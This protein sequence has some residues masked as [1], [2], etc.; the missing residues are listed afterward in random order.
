MF[1]INYSHDI[2]QGIDSPVQPNERPDVFVYIR[3]SVVWMCSSWDTQ[4]WVLYC[5]VFLTMAF[6]SECKTDDLSITAVAVV[7]AG[8]ALSSALIRLQD[9]RS[10]AGPG[11]GV[12]S[13]W[14]WWGKVWT[15]RE[16]AHPLQDSTWAPT[17][18]LL[19]YTGGNLNCV[20]ARFIFLF[21]DKL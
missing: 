8:R 13:R 9:G 10:P 16:R 14:W 11:V 12:W 21:S 17:T 7:K 18:G 19:N 3:S 2:L 15:E 1:L 5:S 4:G 6:T 20:T